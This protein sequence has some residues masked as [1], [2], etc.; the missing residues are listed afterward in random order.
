MGKNYFDKND[1]S[2]LDDYEA[3]RRAQA[4]ANLNSLLGGQNELQN[5]NVSVLDDYEERRRAQ[6]NA[7]LNSFLSG[8]NTSHDTKRYI[9][10][11]N[12]YKSQE[13]SYESTDDAARKYA[14]SRDARNQMDDM[15]RDYKNSRKQKRFVTGK[16][17]RGLSV[18][19]SPEFGFYDDTKTK[20]N[21][22]PLF[23]FILLFAIGLAFMGYGIINPIKTITQ[24]NESQKAINSYT[25]VSGTVTFVSKDGMRRGEQLSYHITYT[26]IYDD[27][28]YKDYKYLSPAS[29][30]KVGLDDTKIRNKT[31]TVYVDPSDPNKSMLTA[32]PY[33]QLYEWLFFPAGII[34]E[35]IAFVYRKKNF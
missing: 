14:Y 33:P 1:F 11:D 16:L 32:L 29:A 6:A 24:A 30:A 15:I 13:R 5:T 10:K 12:L 19:E 26:Y 8:Q 22:H 25:P 23:T 21:R 9:G 2:A 34:L 27:K 20:R 7:N 31:I 18:S 28:E 17:M 4:N 3:R 35:I